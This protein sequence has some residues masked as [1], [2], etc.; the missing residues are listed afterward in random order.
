MNANNHYDFI[1]NMWMDA[2]G[3][4]QN[5]GADQPSR[6]GPTREL[7]G[8][9]TRLNNPRANFLLN[10]VRNISP[11]YAA[12]ELLWYL[13]GSQSG[14]M[15]QAYAPQYSR[16]LD[17]SGNAFGAYGHRWNHDQSFNTALFNSNAQQS[18]F[19][20]DWDRVIGKELTQMNVLGLLLMAKP[21]TRQAVVTMWNAGDLVWALQ[22]GKVDLP[23]TLSLQFLVRENKLNLIATMRSND[24][25]LGMP[26]D[27]WC[28]TCIQQLVAEALGLELGWYQHQAGSLHVYS[29]HLE[30]ATLAAT[31][32]YEIEDIE[33]KKH[34]VKMPSAVK[35]ALV[36]EEEARNEEAFQP[37]SRT[38]ITQSI[39]A[40]GPGS[41]LA[42]CAALCCL[43]HD[44]MPETMR[45]VENRHLANRATSH[46]FK[47]MNKEN[48]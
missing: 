5:L 12:A 47:K 40:I 31:A 19:N 29:K 17:G 38:L 21:D 18:T 23:C 8:Y 24:V 41:L 20:F 35:N 39:I 13:S 2:L 25:W 43:Q 4:I 32:D 22:G 26:Y 44:Q 37:L 45:L 14:E 48:K 1:D 16:F 33:F 9:A 28:F 7:C 36:I 30:K 6:D 15:I 34:A 46:I 42:E 27:V 10:P 11:I 3:M